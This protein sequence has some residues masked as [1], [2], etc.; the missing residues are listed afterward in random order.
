MKKIEKVNYQMILIHEAPKPKEEFYFHG[1]DNALAHDHAQ[2]CLDADDTAVSGKFRKIGNKR[3]IELTK[4]KKPDPIPTT[5][6][7]I[8]EHLTTTV[9]SEVEMWELEIGFQSYHHAYPHKGSIQTIEAMLVK[10][11]P[12]KWEAWKKENNFEM[13]AL[14]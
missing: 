4:T 11:F 1:D 8:F 6:K 10:F 12:E 13:P 2:H 14:Y 3:W 5:L 7:T 9:K